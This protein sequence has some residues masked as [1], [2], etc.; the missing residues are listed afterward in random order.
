MIFRILQSASLATL[1]TL[2]PA[3]L[4]GKPADKAQTEKLRAALES[5]PMGMKVESVSTSELP[6]MFE[7]QFSNGPIVHATAKGDYFIVGDLY[8]VKPEGFVNL[9]EQRRD[10]QR[11]EKLSHVPTEDMIVF[12]PKG[13]TRAYVTVFTDVT[14]FYCQ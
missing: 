11:L 14:C 10:A 1:I 5:S 3:S 7:V 8:E 12:S 6:G 13:E 9:G 2:A 4:A